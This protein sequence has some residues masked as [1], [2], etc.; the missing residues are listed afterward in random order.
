MTDRI[1]R[2]VDGQG[3]HPNRLNQYVLEQMLWHKGQLVILSDKNSVFVFGSNLG[4]I[5][6]AGAAR[7]AC[8]RLHAEIGVAV[9]PTGSCYAIPTKD[10][11]IRHTLPLDEIRKHVQEF[12]RFASEEVP[13][14]RFKVTQIGCGLAGLKPEQI[15]PMFTQ[16]P[17]NCIFD[18]AWLE[19][20][21]NKKF[22]G[23]VP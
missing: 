9:G 2:I 22:W 17:D 6:G 1:T 13:H 3:T 15:A 8:L 16:A 10:A 23:T 11:V 14:N 7:Y 18:T 5:H 21:P 20:L 12:M 4:G 19:W